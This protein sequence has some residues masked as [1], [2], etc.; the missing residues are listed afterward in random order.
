MGF[1]VGRASLPATLPKEHGGG[2]GGPPHERY[3]LANMSNRVTGGGPTAENA[4]HSGR[5]AGPAMMPVI[6]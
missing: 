5:R 6:A 2:H 1:K 3:T 4:G